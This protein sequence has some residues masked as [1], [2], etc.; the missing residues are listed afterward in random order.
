MKASVV[1]TSESIFRTR[2]KIKKKSRNYPI[3]SIIPSRIILIKRLILFVL[4]ALGP[5]PILR[6]VKI[7]FFLLSFSFFSSFSSLFF[8]IILLMMETLF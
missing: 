3:N 6:Y 1:G 5:A 7:F 4:N 2:K 8:K